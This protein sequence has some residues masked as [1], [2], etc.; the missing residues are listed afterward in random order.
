MDKKNI[1]IG[2]L[3][4]GCAILGYLAFK[5]IPKADN[6]YINARIDS[7]AIQNKRLLANVDNLLK[8]NSVLKAANDS[9]LKLPPQIKT[10]YVSVYK[11]VDKLDHKDIT[12][13]LNNIF[14]QNNV[15]TTRKDT[16]VYISPSESKYLIKEHYRNGELTELNNV[17]QEVN[18]NLNAELKNDSLAAKDYN[19]VI[20]NNYERI[21]LQDVEIQNLNNTIKSK[22]R[23][24]FKHKVF[25]WLGI[26]GVAILTGYISYLQVIK[27]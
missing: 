18:T 4:I 5:P 15:D 19:D 3:S 14:T 17:C 13:T 9:L 27:R 23:T 21:N 7:I 10:K 16:L 12:D 24:L 22:D 8:A 2:I 11:Q 6:T 1:I 26:G 25:R 20:K